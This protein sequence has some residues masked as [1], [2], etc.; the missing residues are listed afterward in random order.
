MNINLARRLS[1][2]QVDAINIEYK[3]Q[4]MKVD[5]DEGLVDSLTIQIIVS[6]SCLRQLILIFSTLTEVNKKLYHVFFFLMMNLFS[7]CMEIKR[8]KKKILLSKLISSN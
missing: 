8:L 7:Y 2:G 1:M 6:S 5:T 3:Q 4:E